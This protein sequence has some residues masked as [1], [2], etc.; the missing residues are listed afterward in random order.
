MTAITSAATTSSFEVDPG[1]AAQST[2]PVRLLHLLRMEPQAFNTGTQG[3]AIRVLFR[4][5][6]VPARINRKTQGRS[7]SK[8]HCEPKKPQERSGVH[9]VGSNRTF[10]Y[11]GD[12]APAEDH[13]DELHAGRN[14]NREPFTR[15][16][17]KCS[18]AQLADVERLRRSHVL[19]HTLSVCFFE[20]SPLDLVP[21]LSNLLNARCSHRRDPF[22]ECRNYKN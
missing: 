13:P 11:A 10:A 22:P 14:P 3:A 17:N 9:G 1:C 7:P 8:E 21:T 20:A 2:Q 15:R 18:A 6:R 19:F 16:E 12:Q 4:S 5:R